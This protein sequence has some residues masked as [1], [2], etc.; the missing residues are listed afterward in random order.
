MAYTRI[1]DITDPTGAEDA[2]TIATIFRNNKVDLEE[3]FEDVL[4]EDATDDPWVVKDEV[5]GKVTGKTLMIHPFELG[6]VSY[7]QVDVDSGN[8]Y[9]AC[10]ATTNYGLGIILPVGVTITQI[11]VYIDTAGSVTSR[12]KKG[13]ISGASYIA[14]VLDTQSGG[15]D[16]VSHAGLS[17]TI[18]AL[19]NYWLYLDGTQTWD[20]RGARITYNTPDSRYTY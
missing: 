5:K 14:S 1:W 20:F 17:E 16:V 13:V 10:A 6:S 3:R 15:A 2:N 11:D 19:T 12:F 18:A 4:I 8:G 7:D 9:V